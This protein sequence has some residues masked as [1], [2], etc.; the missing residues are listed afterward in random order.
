[1]IAKLPS[2]MFDENEVNKLISMIRKHKA[3]ILDLRQNPGGDVEA[4]KAVVGSLF[5]HDVKIADRVSRD[6]NKPVLA[7]SNHH[8][9]EG[10]LF[11][12]IDSKSASAAEL[13]A[14]VVQ[15]EKRGTVI[16][17]RS[18]GMVMESRIYTYSSGIDLVTFYA[19]SISDANLIMA[20]GQ[21]LE[22][23]G[24]T[25][26][27]IAI[28]TP[29]EL[30]SGRDPVLVHAAEMAGIKITPEDASKIFPYEWP[31]DKISVVIPFERGEEQTIGN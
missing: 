24:V 7:K 21:S 1:M 22:H 18:S 23:V 2:F 13:L 31:K 15:L 8:P 14:R 26:D 27:E 12:L 19:A 20:D 11:V 17:D 30:A 6:S 5:D 3:L 29:A 10:K 16:G 9:F 28:A 25:P 4:L